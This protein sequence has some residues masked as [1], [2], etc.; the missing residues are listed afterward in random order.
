MERWRLGSASLKTVSTNWEHV[1][2]RP[3]VNWNWFEISNHLKSFSVYMAVSLRSTL[4][5]QTPF[6]NLT[7]PWNKCHYVELEPLRIQTT[8][9]YTA[10]LKKDK[11]LKKKK[12]LVNQSDLA[13]KFD[14]PE[15]KAFFANSFPK[16]III[17]LIIYL[18]H[19]GGCIRQIKRQIYLWF[20]SGKVHK[21]LHW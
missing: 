15:S 11:Y 4:R 17:I 16:R 6:K 21:T 2:M 19:L 10:F 18:H 1:Y 20:L 13:S 3:E 14:L 7:F 9:T 12:N 8:K 5:S